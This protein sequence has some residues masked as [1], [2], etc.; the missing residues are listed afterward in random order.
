MNLKIT[1]FLNFIVLSHKK[2]AVTGA[3]ITGLVTAFVLQQNGVHTELFERRSEPGGAIKTGKNGDWQYEYGPNTLLIKDREVSDFLERLELQDQILT[4]NS[5]SSKRFIIKD[6]DPVP[7][8]MSFT[9]AIKTNLFSFGGKMRV[10]AEPFIGR[11]NDPD[12]TVASFVERRLGYEVLQYGIN[13]FV[14]G[15]FA[16]NPES[17]SVR[18]AFPALY[19]LE[20]N[21]GSLVRGAVSGRKKRKEGRIRRQLISFK[22]GMQVLPEAIAGKLQS[23]H[24][25]HEISK[26]ERSPEGW[27]LI[28]DSEVKGPYS[29]VVVNIPIYRWTRDLLPVSDKQ[30]TILQQVQYQ[31]LSVLIVGYRKSD[32]THPLDGFGF[33]VPGAENRLI[34]GALFSSTLFPGRAPGDSHL[35]TVFIGGG[36][37]PEDAGLP[38]EELF[39][40]VEKEL[41]ELIGLIGE[42]QFKDHI[43]W[44]NAIPAYHPGYDE[45]LKELETIEKENP[46]LHFA[47]NFRGGVSVPDCIKNGL[48]LGGR[49][50]GVV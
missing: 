24:L 26:I 12:E 29:D 47:G 19:D 49:L 30:F 13:P 9:D 38:S 48:D 14:A 20:N 11:S 50:S 32:I 43:F 23:V 44:P 40:R 34:L 25:N 42:P 15:I 21:Y 18:H 6:A 8:P 41:F 39:N 31:P 45:I 36:R 5:A 33:L 10:L 1:D 28:S 27:N 3:G 17:L 37:Q 35:L 16:S 7:L 46:G 22:D 2:I 4:A